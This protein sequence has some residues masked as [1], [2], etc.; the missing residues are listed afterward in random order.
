MN[1]KEFHRL[2]AESK[3]QNLDMCNNLKKTLDPQKCRGFVDA[4]LAHRQN[5]EV[6]KYI[7]QSDYLWFVEPTC[8]GKNS[9]VLFLVFLS[10][11]SKSKI[12]FFVVYKR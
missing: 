11:T 5:L 8:Y 12:F 4:F 3:K 6:R 10:Q 1:R 7:Y 9:S 2:S